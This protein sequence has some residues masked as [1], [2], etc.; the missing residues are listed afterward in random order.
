MKVYI[1]FFVIDNVVTTS[2]ASCLSY[3][4][5][6]IKTRKARV[7]TVTVAGTLV[8]VFYPF[9]SMPTPLI[10]T[11]KL[12]IG[13]ILSLILFAGIFNIAFGAL[14][15]FGATA[16]L[17]G[18]CLAA[19]CFI[20]GDLGLALSSPSQLPY[21]LPS[22]VSIMIYIPAKFIMSNARKRRAES[23]YGYDVYVTIGTKT[24]KMRGYLDTG[25]GL[26]EDGIPIAVTKMNVFVD[27]FGIAVLDEAYAEKTVVG[28]GNSKAHLI[29]V[30]PDKFL[31]YL[32]K[33]RNKYS[34]VIL[35]I[36]ASGFRRSE[37]MLLPVSVLGG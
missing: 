28:I 19:D 20:A 21:C 17:G 25:N 5:T 6:G 14:S 27:K 24:V 23:S 11:A 3:S 10:V 1:E 37:D 4:F 8:S 33:K 18:A 35:G 22:A 15:F 2:L 12:L 9:W 13:I 16:L 29:L 7:L 32:D 26:E 31:L 30:K 36:T 34:D